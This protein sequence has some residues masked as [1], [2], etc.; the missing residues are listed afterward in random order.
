MQDEIN[1]KV[2]AISINAGREGVRLT[3]DLLREALRR[4]LAEQDRRKLHRENNDA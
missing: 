4:Y 3:S 2:I 1:D